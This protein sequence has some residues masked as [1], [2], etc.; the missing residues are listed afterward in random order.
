MEEEPHCCSGLTR[1]FIWQPAG[2]V[3]SATSCASVRQ[4]NNNKKKSTRVSLNK[5][6]THFWR[7]RRPV[8]CASFQH[9]SYLSWAP[10]ETAAKDIY[11][12]I[13]GG[14]SIRQEKAW[15]IH[16]RPYRFRQWFQGSCSFFSFLFLTRLV[17]CY[18]RKKKPRAVSFR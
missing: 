12:F 7:S 5:R 10:S 2:A 3:L 16:D 11:S 14:K 13:P 6:S 17:L 1:I 4:Y 15:T 8:T 9:A 18:P